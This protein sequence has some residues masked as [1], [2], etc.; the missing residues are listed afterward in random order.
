MFT[1][2]NFLELY[3]YLDG[4]MSAGFNTLQFDLPLLAHHDPRFATISHHYD[5]LADIWSAL[6]RREYGWSLDSIC[7]ATFGLKKSG[8]GAMAPVWFQ[9]GKYGQVIDYCLRDVWLEAKLIKHMLEGNAVHNMRGKSVVVNPRPL[10]QE[11]ISE[12]HGADL[13]HA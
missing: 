8:H 4:Q 12:P 6:G 10:M 9:Q 11:L 7:E 1:D 5:A 3:P 2:D 13:P